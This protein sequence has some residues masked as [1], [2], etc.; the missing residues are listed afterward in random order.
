EGL[1]KGIF[2]LSRF[3][4][5][6]GEF[7]D[8]RVYDFQGDTVNG[9]GVS[10]SPTSRFLYI[11]Q[12]LKIYQYDLSAPD[13]QASRQVVAKYDGFAPNGF[14][15]TF[16]QGMLAPDHK[17]YLTAGNSTQYLH[18]IHAPDSLGTACRVQ[19]HGL[20]LATRHAFMVPNFPYFRLYDLA[21]S[22]CDTLGIN[23]PVSAAAEPGG[24]GREPVSFYPNPTTGEVCWWSAG[25]AAQRLLVYSTT[26][27]RLLEQVRTGAC[28]DLSDLPDGLYWVLLLD[29]ARQEVGRGKVLLLRD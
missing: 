16:F 6:S 7:Y 5:C 12:P 21:G 14:S 17:I 18:I 1:G 23:G 13:L 29:E 10:F 19:Q 28:A 2:R 11:S 25:L 9:M 15:T 22:V 27:Q 3:D 26:G 24:Q 4:R 8:Q 20:G